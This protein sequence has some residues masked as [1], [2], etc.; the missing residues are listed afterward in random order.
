MRWGGSPWR[1]Y[2]EAPLQLIKSRE[3]GHHPGYSGETDPPLLRGEGCLLDPRALGPLFLPSHAALVCDLRAG[4]RRMTGSFHLGFG[5]K[6]SN[7]FGSPAPLAWPSRDTLDFSLLCRPN[8]VHPVSLTGIENL[9][10][11]PP[12]MQLLFLVCCETDQHIDG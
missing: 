7:Q 3:G 9:G 12:D 5:F 2:I 10:S 4:A 11:F 1:G 8:D 6:I